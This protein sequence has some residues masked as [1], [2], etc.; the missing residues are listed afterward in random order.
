MKNLRIYFIVIG[1]VFFKPYANSQKN[2]VLDSSFAING[3]FTLNN[4]GGEY[5]GF[6]VTDFF[7]IDQNKDIYFGLGQFIFPNSYAIVGKIDSTGVL[8]ED[9]GEAG[10]KQ[11]NFN[12]LNFIVNHI[13]KL[14]SND[15]V[16]AYQLYNEDIGYENTFLHK[17]NSE[18]VDDLNFG[19]NGYLDLGSISD[20]SIG[21][22]VEVDNGIVGYFRLGEEFGLM[23]F[24]YNGQLD[25]TFG[26]NGIVIFEPIAL[27]PGTWIT[28]EL[29]QP[30][31]YSNGSIFV[32]NFTQQDDSGT[33]YV[34]IHKFDTD[35]KIDLEW[36]NSNDLNMELPGESGLYTDQLI[37]DND[38]SIIFSLSSYK[39]NHDI[40]KIFKVL[41][42]GE[43]DSNFKINGVLNE[44]STGPG[45]ELIVM[46]SIEI[47]SE[48]NYWMVFFEPQANFSKTRIYKFDKNGNPIEN[49]GN[50]G[51]LEL[52]LA[53]NVNE[54]HWNFTVGERGIF[55]IGSE[56]FNENDEANDYVIRKFKP[57]SS[58]SSNI[59][60]SL[61]NDIEIFSSLEALIIKNKGRTFDA[62]IELS[63]LN[64]NVF[65]YYK[66]I[67][68]NKGL[69]KF[70]YYNALPSGIYAVR[71]KNEFTYFSR[72]VYV[73]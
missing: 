13:I 28:V 56:R 41:T 17:Y 59:I 34:Q 24:D 61:D 71:V 10:I 25:L 15:I 8:D 27:H 45:E 35:G 46:S 50:N 5:D 22:L 70:P 20:V 66:N 62:D 1:M 64:G 54:N 39:D 63:G 49:F 3:K 16:S 32:L 36:E 33:S 73:Y 47:D 43:L 37:I 2:Y 58:L 6:S 7:E 65:N 21:G 31:A 11:S 26:D 67:K 42:N 44:V 23:K 48:N 60:K 38:G 52:N 55:F 30:I 69:N 4:S 18:G 9:F 40:I 14:R 51:V 53:E 68:L 57:S 72:L 12:N 29:G 19:D